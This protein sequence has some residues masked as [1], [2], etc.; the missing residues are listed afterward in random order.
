METVQMIDRNPSRMEIELRQK[1]IEQTTQAGQAKSC[2]NKFRPKAA[3]AA[4]AWLSLY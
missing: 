2:S 1:R 3:T 4:F